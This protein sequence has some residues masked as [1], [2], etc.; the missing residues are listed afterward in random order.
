MK[1]VLRHLAFEEPIDDPRAPSELE[2]RRLALLAHTQKTR[3]ALLTNWLD[4]LGGDPAFTLDHLKN[5]FQAEAVFQKQREGYMK[6][7]DWIR[8][9][10]RRD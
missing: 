4:Y 8:T 2:S 7:A 5:L 10:I 3:T 6:C 9:T 1:K